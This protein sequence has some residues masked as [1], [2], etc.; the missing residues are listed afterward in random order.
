MSV[1]LI[2]Q[3]MVR[4]IVIVVQMVHWIHVVQ[5][6]HLWDI[7]IVMWIRVILTHVLPVVI[8]I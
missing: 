7:V 5:H 4:I 8:W 3:Y 6:V 1:L 2:V